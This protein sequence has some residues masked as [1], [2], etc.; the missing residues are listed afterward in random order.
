MNEFRSK[1]LGLLRLLLPLNASGKVMEMLE[2]DSVTS[3][4]VKEY[5]VKVKESAT[6]VKDYGDAARRDGE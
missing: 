5:V 1:L 3:E 4:K 6:E 2:D